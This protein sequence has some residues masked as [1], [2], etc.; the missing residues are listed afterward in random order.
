M[1]IHVSSMLAIDG[2]MINKQPATMAYKIHKTQP[3]WLRKIAIA[4]SH[5]GLENVHAS[6]STALVMYMYIPTYIQTHTYINGA[7]MHTHVHIT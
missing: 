3:L 2:E 1:K 5:N 4:I 7:Y 6:C